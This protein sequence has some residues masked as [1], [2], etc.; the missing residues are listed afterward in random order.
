M[1]TKKILILFILT[2]LVVGCAG[3]AKKINNLTLGM[4]KSEVIET[5]GKPDYSNVR[6]EVEILNYRL[7]SNSLFTDAYIVRIKQGKVDL[8]G[9]RGDFG[10]IY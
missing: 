1:L 8:F 7:T 9:R 2:V 5:M 3:S 10:S 4:T 6:E